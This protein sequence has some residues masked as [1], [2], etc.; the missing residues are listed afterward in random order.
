MKHDKKYIAKL[1]LSTNRSSLFVH[2]DPRAPDV[3][4][5]PWLRHQAQLVLQFGENLTIPITDMMLTAIGISGTLSFARTPYTCFVPWSAVFALV[6]DD[7]RGQV[8]DES[9]PQEIKDEMAT[10]SK[11]SAKHRQQ[12]QVV[13][14][15]VASGMLPRTKSGRVLPIGW[16]VIDGGK[17][18]KPKPKK[19][20]KRTKKNEGPYDNAS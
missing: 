16:R 7:G 5:P 19:R 4:V 8:F 10:A 14:E 6:G 1:I 20:A 2:L 17:T 3:I 13:K 18:A 11:L 12:F 9:M 15:T